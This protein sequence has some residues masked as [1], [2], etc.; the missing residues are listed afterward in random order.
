MKA[1]QILS[2]MLLVFICSCTE[3]VIFDFEENLS[4]ELEEI[5]DFIA[6]HNFPAEVHPTEIRYRVINEGIGEPIKVDDTVFFNYQIYLLDSTLMDTNLEEVRIANNL[7]QGNGVPVRDIIYSFSNFSRPGFLN[8][9]YTLGRERSEIHMLVPSHEA[10]GSG[11]RFFDENRV[12]PPYTPLLIEVEIVEV[13]P[14]D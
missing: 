13:R 9:A 3:E 7:P 4:R 2:V 6:R 5:N 11:G 12:V 8:V 10:Y 14:G 1:N